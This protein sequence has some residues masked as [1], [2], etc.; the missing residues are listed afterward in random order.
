MNSNNDSRQLSRLDGPILALT[1]ALA[2]FMINRWLPSAPPAPPAAHAG[3]VSNVA[4]STIITSSAGNGEDLLMV[5]DQ[6]S[7]TILV[8]RTTPRRT[9]ELLQVAPVQDLFDQARSA[10]PS[11]RR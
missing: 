3:L 7:E 9:M 2:V 10:G 1:A 11:N 6:R 5:L 8:Y 4:D